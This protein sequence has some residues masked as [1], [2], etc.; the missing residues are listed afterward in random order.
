[1]GIRRKMT[2]SLVLKIP[3]QGSGEQ[4]FLIHKGQDTS[5]WAGSEREREKAD[6]TENAQGGG[7]E[8]TPDQFEWKEGCSKGW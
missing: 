1:M 6:S 8:L 7:N 4:S 2:I 3:G 5:R